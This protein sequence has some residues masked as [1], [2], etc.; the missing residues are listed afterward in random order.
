L[1]YFTAGSIS[2]RKLLNKS[3]NYTNILVQCTTEC[4]DSSIP[5]TDLWLSSSDEFVSSTDKD[6]LSMDGSFSSID[7]NY[8]ST[9]E[10]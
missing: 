1:E 7:K 10:Q 9:D 6:I 4:K 2:G 8:Y 5:L 3:S